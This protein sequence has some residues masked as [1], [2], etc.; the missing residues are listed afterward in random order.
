MKAKIIIIKE[1]EI[2]IDVR[3]ITLLSVEEYEAYRENIKSIA[4]WWWLR[5]LGNTGHSL[6]YIFENGIVRDDGG[7]YNSYGSVRPALIL[8]TSSLQIKD[9][10][11][12]GGKL[13]TVIGE[14]IALSDEEFCKMAFR[15]DWKAKDANNYA[16]SDIKKYLDNWLVSIL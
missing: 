14:E 3:E 2:D 15:K 4:N 11:E 1:K 5:S 8:N 13:W 9:K 12:L 7:V 10:F 6:F 16:A